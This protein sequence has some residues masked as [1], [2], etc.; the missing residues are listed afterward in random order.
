MTDN[1]AEKE[2]TLDEWMDEIA[3]HR[4]AREYQKLKTRAEQ[5]GQAVGLLT[6]LHPTMVMDPDNPVDMAKKI[7]EHMKQPRLGYATT[8]MLLEELTVR[9]EVD[10]NLD[11]RTV[12]DK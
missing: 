7:I 4:A 5:L 10:G 1:N 8:R 12:D 6:T 9:I 2:M 11:Y 3:D